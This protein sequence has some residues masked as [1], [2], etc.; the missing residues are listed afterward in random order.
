MCGIAGILVRPNSS[1]QDLRERLTAM[2]VAMHH[3]GPDDQGICIDP[4]GQV[5]LANRR[6]AIRDLSPA[7]HMPMGTDD[8]NIWI[9]YNG[10][11][12]NA[13]ELRT[14]LEGQGDYFHSQSDTEVILHGY[15]AWGQ[16]VVT[17]LRGMFAFAILDL[18]PAHQHLFLARAF[19][20]R[21]AGACR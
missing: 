16:T 21:G 13:A 11:V 5:G 17:R 2:A 10:E 15:R 8:G 3:R 9:T 18:R 1:M 19:F 6:L 7:G 12:Y 20:W 14:E 4:S